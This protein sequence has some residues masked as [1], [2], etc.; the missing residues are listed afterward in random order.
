MPD[1]IKKNTVLFHLFQCSKIVCRVWHGLSQDEGGHAVLLSRPQNQAQGS[2]YLKP[3][4]IGT[5]LIHIYI[6]IKIIIIIRPTT[7][8]DT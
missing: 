4:N 7:E 5:K 3:W 8:R 2:H 6:F 1:L